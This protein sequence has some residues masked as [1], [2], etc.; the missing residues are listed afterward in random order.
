MPEREE[1]NDQQMFQRHLRRPQIQ[2]QR[3]LQHPRDQIR[4]EVL[5]LLTASSKISRIFSR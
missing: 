3:A 2:P 4:G 1:S 5:M